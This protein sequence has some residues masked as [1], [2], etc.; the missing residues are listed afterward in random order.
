MLR[1][2]VATRLNIVRQI[3]SRFLFDQE[4]IFFA[5]FFYCLRGYA[6]NQVALR[7]QLSCNYRTNSND[8]FRRHRPTRRNPN[9]GSD[10]RERSDIYRAR[11]LA[12][13]SPEG[14]I[15]PSQ[16]RSA[17]DRY[18]VGKIYFVPGR[19]YAPVSERKPG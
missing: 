8:T 15:P 11:A 2:Q 12:V 9:F 10:V 7:G 6:G 4:P 13:V 16:N 17:S 19:N 5:Q 14:R 3:Y 1:I 18:A